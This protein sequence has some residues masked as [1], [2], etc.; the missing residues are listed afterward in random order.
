MEDLQGDPLAYTQ[1]DILARLYFA[2]PGMLETMGRIATLCK[3]MSAANV[4]LE[5]QKEAVDI[6]EDANL[7]MH[8]A[9]GIEIL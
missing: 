6:L 4:D 2:A 9:I 3:K 5:F 1:S 7:V 8:A